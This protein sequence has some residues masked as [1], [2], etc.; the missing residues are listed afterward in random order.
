MYQITQACR[1]SS[2]CTVVRMVMPC[3]RTSS[4]CQ[5]NHVAMRAEKVL[6]KEHVA[7]PRACKRVRVPT[8]PHEAA[9]ESAQQKRW[10]GKSP[11][12]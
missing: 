4:F 8:M 5:R 7:K 3:A 11:V 2:S 6:S 10:A 9:D 1:N 12:D